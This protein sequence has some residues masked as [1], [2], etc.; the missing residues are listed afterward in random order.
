MA[1][2]SGIVAAAITPNLDNIRAWAEALESG[3][4]PQGRNVLRQ[5]APDG[6]LEYCCLGVAVE[7]AVRAGVQPH[8]GNRFCKI[9][10]DVF[11]QPEDVFSE[12]PHTHNLW[13]THL[14]D[15]LPSEVCEWLGI[16][17]ANPSLGVN[18]LEVGSSRTAITLNDDLKQSFVQIAARIR[19]KYLGEDVEVADLH[20]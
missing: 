5:D 12:D 16:T 7:L 6:S 4:F 13:C 17:D 20:Q 1:Q 18:T 15:D 9:I 19:R 8:E 14:E 11:T 10:D 2:F 3:E